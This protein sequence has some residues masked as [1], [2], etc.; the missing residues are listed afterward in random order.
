MLGG[1]VTPCL[2]FLVGWWWG[3]DLCPHFSCKKSVGGG[4]LGGGGAARPSLEATSMEPVQS[5]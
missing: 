3:G 4:L 5:L 1:F 2:W